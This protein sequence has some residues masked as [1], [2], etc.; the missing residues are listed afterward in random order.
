MM[1]CFSYD[2]GTRPLLVS[3]PHDGRQLP[4]DIASGM[5]EAG[6]AIP[7]TDWHVGRLY[8][9]ARDLGAHV[10]RA[11]YSRYV[12]DL[13][14]PA[15]DSHLY[16]GRY[17]SGLCPTQTFAGED[18]YQRGSAI[19]MDERV[20]GYWLP[21]H[22]KLAALLEQIRGEHGHVLLWDAHSIPSSVPR[23]F[24]GVLPVLNLGTWDQRSCAAAIAA[25]VMSVATASPYDAVLN[26]RFV[27]GYITRHYGRPGDG[28]HAIQLE[29]AQRSYMDEA[30]L[31]YDPDKA[32]QLQNT[33]SA[34]LRA[35]LV[36]AERYTQQAAR[37]QD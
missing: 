18:I 33:L 27:G 4:C 8:D 31:E 29:L 25:A 20:S 32:S 6:R 1:D 36:A 28:V 21:Y 24:D 14:R 5:T 30:T 22:D 35:C 23:L 3:V 10:I 15:D 13:N 19:D 12:V 16:A 2:A 7:D 37:G 26:G 34:M 17:G 9:F 11:E